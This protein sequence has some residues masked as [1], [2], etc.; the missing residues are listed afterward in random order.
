M[1]IIDKSGVII[2]KD[3]FGNDVSVGDKVLYVGKHNTDLFL[4]RR[5]IKHN[6][7]TDVIKNA[8]GKITIY[9]D[10]S[11]IFGKSY[12]ICSPD[13]LVKG[14]NLKNI[15]KNPRFNEWLNHIHTKY[16]IAQ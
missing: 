4:N 8:N 1:K 12:Y 7:I 9:F 15:R 10:F 13:D 14:E 5:F 16:K 2:F 3:F 11:N 6:H